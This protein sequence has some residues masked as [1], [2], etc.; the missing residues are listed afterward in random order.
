MDGMHSIKGSLYFA[1]NMASIFLQ[2]LIIL[3]HLDDQVVL[4]QS[5]QMMT[6]LEENY[7]LTSLI[8]LFKSLIADLMR[9]T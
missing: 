4:F 3:F 2:W 8:E 1:T 7:I 5:K 6:T 9:L